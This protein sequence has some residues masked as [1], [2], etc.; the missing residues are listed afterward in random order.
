MVDE[1][2]PFPLEPRLP[3]SGTKGS[4]YAVDKLTII[5]NAL[6][7]T[8]N[9]PVAVISDG[10]DEWIA[11]S[12]FYDRSLPKLLVSHDWKFALT[13][14]EMNKAGFSRYPGFQ[15]VYDLPSDCLLLRQAYDDRLAR[16]I[17]PVDTWTISETGINLPEM[18]YRIISDQIHCI[19]PLGASCLYVQN[20]PNG[21]VGTVGFSEAL[22]TEIENLLLRG[23]NE[24]V[25]TAIKHQALVKESLTVAREQDS[26]PEPRRILFRSRMLERRRRRGNGVW[27]LW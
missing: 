15:D 20:P 12:N 24:D 16:L 10:S 5:N 22:T 1:T 25:D 14:A 9:Q 17:K 23:F 2:F 13:I 3:N 27:G 21:T 6:L 18:D 26:S 19:A 7:A 4:P 11:A 8:G